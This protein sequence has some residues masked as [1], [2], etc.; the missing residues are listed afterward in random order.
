VKA[1]SDLFSHDEI[2][3]NVGKLFEAIGSIDKVTTFV[4]D[5]SKKKDSVFVEINN[6]M[7]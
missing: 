5:R 7:V 3:M 6:E 1:L 4:N 2:L